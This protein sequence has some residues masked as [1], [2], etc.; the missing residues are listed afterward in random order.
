MQDGDLNEFGHYGVREIENNWIRMPD[1]VHLAARIWIP[2]GEVP[3]PTI[4]TYSPYFARLFTRAGDDARYPYYASRGYACVRVDIRGSGDSEGVS[5][6][7]YVLQEQDD[8][9][10]VIKWIAE[11]PWCSGA[12]GMEGISWSGF[13]ALQIASRRPPALRAIITHCS[14]DDRYTDDAHYKG[15]CIIHDMFNWGALFLAFQ[16]QAP[17]PEIVGRDG[18]KE[19]W[20]RRLEAVDFNLGHWLEHQHRD[21][22]WRHG[23]I[24]ED[25]TRIVCPVYAIGGWVD[26]YKNA[27]FRL[28]SG[29]KV[30]RKG[31]IG[32]WTHIYPHQGVPG[33]AIG[34]LDEALRWWDHWLKGSNTGIMDE[35]MFRVWMQDKSATP[36]EPL[37]PG[38][39]VA[40]DL[41]PSSRITSKSYYLNELQTLDSIKGVESELVLRPLQSVGSA[42]GNWCPSGMGGHQDLDAELPLDQRFDDS[43]SLLFDTAPLSESLEILGSAV[44]TLHLTVDRPVAFL[45]VRLNEVAATG[46][47]RRVT[48][49]ILNLCHRNGSETPSAIKP[50]VRY[51]VSVRLDNVARRLAADSRIRIAI[52][53]TYWPMILPAPAPV[54]LS[55]FAAVSTL[56]LPV[57]P[58]RSSDALLRPFG[59]AVVP[60]VPIEVLDSMP[61]VH[62]A[63][64]NSTNEIQVIRHEVGTGKFLLTAVNTRLITQNKMRSEIGEYDTTATMEYTHS[65]GWERGQWRPKVCASAKVT[66]TTDFFVLEGSINAFDG[67][68]L[69]FTRSWTKNILRKFV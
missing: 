64:R 56:E 22:L 29:L 1:G 33:P 53:T 38:R 63:E 17:D 61:G 14:T 47:S 41:W 68:Q 20:L 52:S 55:V 39:W 58:P 66:T 35:P 31:L 32:P 59:S 15:G 50:G 57:R 69:V 62:V 5:L 18:W 2:E 13:N 37:V 65:L 9:V 24:I 42:S 7:E 28:L 45:A 8:G 6:D 3:V 11:Q 10:E 67:E 51:V 23:S 21:E 43:R 36:R 4:F 46:E 54:N 60:T 12:V 40:E 49:G 25:Y 44:V 19:R 16:G 30:P 26:G 34:Y 27:V 48:Y